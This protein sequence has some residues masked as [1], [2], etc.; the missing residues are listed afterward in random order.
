MFKV[1]IRHDDHCRVALRDNFHYHFIM[2]LLLLAFL[3]FLVIYEELIAITFWIFLVISTAYHFDYAKERRKRYWFKEPHRLN[4]VIIR[5]EGDNRKM[6][7][8]VLNK[9]R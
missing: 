5:E 4:G 3:D 8:S 6:P 9:R 1:C 2:L 7:K